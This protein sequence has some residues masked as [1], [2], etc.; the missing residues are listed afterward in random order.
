[1]D[2]KDKA[3]ELYS[4]FLGYCHSTHAKKGAS[5]CVDEIINSWEEDGNKRLDAPV[6]AYW[7]E[8]KREINNPA[9]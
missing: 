5:L 2:A 4:K 7:E 8:V 1:M 3:K 6:I 9:L